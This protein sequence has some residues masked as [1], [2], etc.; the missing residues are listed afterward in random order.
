MA[1][2]LSGGEQQMLA[3]G[4]DGGPPFQVHAEFADLRRGDLARTGGEPECSSDPRLN[5]E[6]TLIARGVRSLL[7][8]P[9]KVR[10]GRA[11]GALYVEAKGM[12]AFTGDSAE[13]L[14]VVANAAG[15]AIDNVNLMLRL[16]QQARTGGI[17]ERFLS[18]PRAFSA[19][20]GAQSFD[21]RPRAAEATFLCAR[22]APPL[23][24]REGE[25]LRQCPAARCAP[26]HD[27]LPSSSPLREVSGRAGR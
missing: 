16:E 26:G 5:G 11:V 19:S 7:I 10:D 12:A 15:L 2:Q 3:I 23:R 20:V 25:P 6:A 27:Q 8:A 9:V 13:L 22:P 24:Q 21:L 1:N 17:Y 4:R 14:E 18:A